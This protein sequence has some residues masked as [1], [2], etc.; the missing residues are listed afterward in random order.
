[1]FTNVTDTQVSVG[2]HRSVPYS[3]GK[4]IGLNEAAVAATATAAIEATGTVPS[5][6]FPVGLQCTPSRHARKCNVTSLFTGQQ[7]VTFGSKFV[8]NANNNLQASGGAPGNWDWVDVG[9]GNG[10]SALGNC[11]TEW[12]VRELQL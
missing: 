11:A 7:I 12:G 3:F 9:Q 8:L 10:A 2:I 6:M 4:M 5:G 1:M